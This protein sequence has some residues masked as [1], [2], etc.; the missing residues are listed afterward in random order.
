MSLKTYTTKGLS[1][2]MVSNKPMNERLRD[3]VNKKVIILEFPRDTRWECCILDLVLFRNLDIFSASRSGFTANDVH[4]LGTYKA[5]DGEIV[6][7]IYLKAN[8]ERTTLS[9]KEMKRLIKVMGE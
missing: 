9:K 1:G 6:P 3:L 7:V 4:H 8:R 2:E 5:Y